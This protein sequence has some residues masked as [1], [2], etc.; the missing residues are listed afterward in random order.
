MEYFIPLALLALIPLGL[1][2][3]AGETI[4]GLTRAAFL[5]AEYDYRAWRKAHP[6]ACQKHSL[7]A[8]YLINQCLIT[9]QDFL[10]AHPYINDREYRAYL[11]YALNE[12]ICT[13]D[14][15]ENEITA[16]QVAVSLFDM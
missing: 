16:T 13:R 2:A 3:Q 7:K 11:L 5:D 14:T 9:H 6:S 4:A 8:R 12:C 1:I 15:D 10:N